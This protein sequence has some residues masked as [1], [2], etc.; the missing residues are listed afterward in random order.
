MVTQDCNPKK[1]R[2]DDTEVRNPCQL[3]MCCLIAANSSVNACSEVMDRIHLNICPLQWAQC[4]ASPVEGAGETLQEKRGSWLFLV[5]APWVGGVV[6]RKFGEEVNNQLWISA[7]S[8]DVSWTKWCS[9]WMS[10]SFFPGHLMACSPSLWTK[11]PWWQAWRLGMG[12]TSSSPPEGW[13]GHSHCW[14]CN[15]LTMEINSEPRI[16]HRS[17]AG[18]ASHLLVDWLHWTSSREQICVPTEIGIY[19]GSVFVFPA[20]N[21]SAST[22]I[23]G[24][25]ECLI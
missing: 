9:L 17:S 21:A 2:P 18:P 4:W 11:L 6:V 8:E 14:V 15:L 20:D 1:Q 3:S 7:Q 16:W 12:K 13:P 25:T 22:T 19:S 23:H 24:P 10:I 5:V